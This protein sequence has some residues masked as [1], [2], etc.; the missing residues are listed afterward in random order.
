MQPHSVLTLGSA[1]SR[2]A[3]VGGA[4]PS[5]TPNATDSPESHALGR[6]VLNELQI[7]VTPDTLLRWY[8]Q[9]VASKS[10]YGHRRG[11][12]RPRVMKTIV[13]L[14]LRMALENRSWGYTRTKAHG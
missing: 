7:L 13:E 6:K 4:S 1:F 2:T 5:A 14:V 10:N 3:W 12:G 8:R 9:L 11:P